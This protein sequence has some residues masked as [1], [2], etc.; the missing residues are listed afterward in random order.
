L[1]SAGTRELIKLDSLVLFQRFRAKKRVR[2]P[3]AVSKTILCHSFY[4]TELGVED[5]KTE[6]R[7]E[8]P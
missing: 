2:A 1:T 8:S 5:M 3:V 7:S 4:G 6:K